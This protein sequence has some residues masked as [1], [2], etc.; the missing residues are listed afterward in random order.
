MRSLLALCNHI[1]Q[2]GRE[3]KLQGNTCR[4]GIAY[5]TIS[6]Q[7]LHS[8]QPGCRGIFEIPETM[9]TG[10]WDDWSGIGSAATQDN[11]LIPM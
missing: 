10:T 9:P 5:T 1:Q 4:E 2:P 6:R 7:L 8:R 11:A 3:A